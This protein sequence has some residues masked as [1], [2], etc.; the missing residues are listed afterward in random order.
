MRK[1]KIP[2][3]LAIVILILLLICGIALF[4]LKNIELNQQKQ[5]YSPT[6]YQVVNITTDSFSI[7]WQTPQPC[8]A[9]LLYGQTQNLDQTQIDDR[10][11]FELKPRLTHFVTIKSLQPDTLYYVKL[12]CSQLITPDKPLEVITAPLIPGRDDPN[13][14]PPLRGTILDQSLQPIDEAL[15]LLQIPGAQPLATFSTSAGNFLLPLTNVRN[16]QLDQKFILNDQPSTLTIV[17]G[18]QKTTADL[19]IPLGNKDLPPFTLG[20]DINLVNYFASPSPTIQSN[21][22]FSKAQD[23]SNLTGKF[24]LNQDGKINSLDLSI[25]LQNIGKKPF[26]KRADINQDLTVDQKD[27][28]LLKQA[29]E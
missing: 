16:D 13:L 8:F 28:E 5:N 17:K 18:D 26:E 7:L 3:I 25:I 22:A 15:I 19:K 1:L 20:Q 27:V 29:L 24:D 10:D 14:N 11:V 12:K 2:T 21:N 4:S 9:K 23:I 6:N